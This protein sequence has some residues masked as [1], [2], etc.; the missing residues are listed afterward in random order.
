MP[1][2]SFPYTREPGDR[3]MVA[4]AIANNEAP[5]VTSDHL[6]NAEYPNAIW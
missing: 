1:T 2:L 4:N 3:I 5:L 6:I